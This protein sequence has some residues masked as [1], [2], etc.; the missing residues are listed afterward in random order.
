MNETHILAG[1]QKKK[2]SGFGGKR[3]GEETFL[4]TALRETLEELL[5]IKVPPGLLR[6]V[7]DNIIPNK[8]ILRGFYICVLYNFHQLIDILYLTRD[9]LSSSPVYTEI[10]RTLSDLILTR[11]PRETSE[12]GHLC[13]LPIVKDISIDPLFIQ[14]LN[15]ITTP[16]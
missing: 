15:S 10:P 11:R 14:D 9:Y 1:Y 4:Q 12:I 7:T 8:V 16:K 6:S 13:L 2:L 5:D 3:E